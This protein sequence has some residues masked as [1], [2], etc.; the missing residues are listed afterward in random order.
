MGETNEPYDGPERRRS[1]TWMTPPLTDEP[2]PVSES[3]L[4]AGVLALGDSTDNLAK[5][6]QHQT[7][8]RKGMTVLIVLTCLCLIG[9]CIVGG[10]AFQRIS[11]VDNTATNLTSEQAQREAVA[12]ADFRTDRTIFCVNSYF[13]S[14]QNGTVYDARCP[15]AYP[16]VPITP[17]PTMP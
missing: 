7:V 6:I 14:V 9:F 12:R 1:R 17:S 4:L 11:R 13:A 15:Q 8:Q 10:L 2:S 16:G 3:S 5:R